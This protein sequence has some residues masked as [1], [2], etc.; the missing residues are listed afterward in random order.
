MRSIERVLTPLAVL[1]G[2]GVR[3]VRS[4]ATRALNYVDPFLLFDDFSSANPD[5][6]IKGFPWHP[7]RG[8]ETVTYIL[9]GLVAHRDSLGNAGRI[10]AG[11][12]QWMTSGSGIMHEEMPQKTEA[13]LVG[14]QLWVNLPAAKKMITPRYQDLR[15]DQIPVVSSADGA[16]VRVIAGAFGGTTGP[17]RDI[18]AAPT[19]LD[20]QLAPGAGIRLPAP[21]G[22]AACAYLFDGAARFGE[23]AAAPGAAAS[24]RA[25]SAG[26]APG[27][28][29]SGD[30]SAPAGAEDAGAPVE[31]GSAASTATEEAREARRLIVFGDGGAVAARAGA[32]GAR[33][34]LIAGAPLHEPIAR[35]GP[36]VMNTKQEI[37]EALDDL[38]RGTFIRAEP[39]TGRDRTASTETPADAG[40]WYGRAAERE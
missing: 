17:V 27:A 32:G 31:S 38:E 3:L 28:A 20:V 13:P 21:A 22:H 33:F 7:H 6:H 23:D 39:E 26:A 2:A 16:T 24:A 11:E 14:F 25:T 1:E 18:A 15:A 36:F 30:K 19:Y 29:A 4:I 5:D 40:K 9:S 37:R 8:I 12:V 34:L 10:G 35:Y